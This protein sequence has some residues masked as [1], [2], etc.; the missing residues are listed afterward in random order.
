M[1]KYF[2]QFFIIHLLK[3]TSV[4]T[5]TK[6]CN[7]SLQTVSTVA[8]CPTNDTS[9]KIAAQQKNCSSLPMDRSSCDSFEY[10]CVL[11]E[12]L[13]TAI[14]VC[15]PSLNIIGHSCAMFSKTLT[16]IMRV[17]NITCGNA[18]K[19]CPFSYN[20]TTSFK[21]HHCF[22]TGNQFY[23]TEA[24]QRKSY[25]IIIV[26]V[27]LAIG[28]ICVILLFLIWRSKRRRREEVQG[29]EEVEMDPIVLENNEVNQYL[30]QL[31]IRDENESNN[32]DIPPADVDNPDQPL[33]ND[34]AENGAERV[35][36]EIPENRVDVNSE[37]RN[38]G[39]LQARAKIEVNTLEK[40]EGNRA[41]LNCSMNLL[42]NLLKKPD[43]TWTKEKIIQEVQNMIQKLEDSKETDLLVKFIKT[44]DQDRNIQTKLIKCG[45]EM[46]ELISSVQ[47]RYK[48]TRVEINDG[49]VCFMF[50][51]SDDLSLKKLS[52]EFYRGDKIFRNCISK[53]LLNQA[54]L[55]IFQIHPETVTWKTCELKVYKGAE[56]VEDVKPESPIIGTFKDILEEDQGA[57]KVEDVKPESPIIGTFKD[58]LEEDK[59]AEKVED[60]K[61]ESPIIGTFKDMLEEDQGEDKKM[62]SILDAFTAGS[63]KYPA[64]KLF[65][66]REKSFD[67]CSGGMKK[68]TVEFARDG[69]FYKGK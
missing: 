37:R 44:I 45:E 42:V 7:A 10:H 68:R 60:E 56:K 64:Y 9:Y 21:Y 5:F 29:R 3:I 67:G 41:M 36:E 2:V 63:N 31:I 62:E 8:E 20:S 30:Q 26:I 12:D 35:V 14:E 43:S 57:E 47:E 46:F 1:G 19:G 40:D 66:T 11:S 33:L 55:G 65:K 22:P 39:D 23:T 69:F 13:K 17:D 28:V 52:K 18:T 53:I 48:A 61:L 59:G 50:Y 58:M 16:G 38:V 34:Q 32:S 54:F 6:P 4:E 15:A 51:F 25:V 24:I 27:I 49:C